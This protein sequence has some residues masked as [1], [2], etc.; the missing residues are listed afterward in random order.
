MFATRLRPQVVPCSRASWDN[1][2]RTMSWVNGKCGF[3]N[4]PP[5][6]TMSSITMIEAIPQPPRS[7]PGASGRRGEGRRPGRTC[8]SVALPPPE[9]S[10]LALAQ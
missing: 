6:A 3:M 10:R 4:F 8:A 5:R 2:S 7:A 1:V 9:P